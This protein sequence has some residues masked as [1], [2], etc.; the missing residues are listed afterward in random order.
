MSLLDKPTRCIL[1]ASI[2]AVLLP[3]AGGAMIGTAFGESAD[4]IGQ[5]VP[6]VDRVSGQLTQIS[7]QI[8]Q[9][10][11]IAINNTHSQKDDA[12]GLKQQLAAVDTNLHVLDSVL[13]AQHQEHQDR[14]ENLQ[15]T[16]RWLSLV[17]GILGVLVAGI[18]LRLRQPSRPVVSKSAV[19][20]PAATQPPIPETPAEHTT[21]TA[22]APTT[23]K[24]EPTPVRT[25]GTLIS[26]DLEQTHQTFIDAQKS[27]MKPV[28]IDED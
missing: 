2:A 28:A 23:A 26:E 14:L 21:P 16:N 5:T 12:V 27:F 24:P 8:G 22:V 18:L 19:A 25:I 17:V 13:K 11:Q 3:L 4:T 10:R 9:L 6:T 1:T 7:R 20:K 15:S